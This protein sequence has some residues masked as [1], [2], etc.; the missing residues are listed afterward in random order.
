MRIME[1]A[2]LPNG[3]H[4]NQECHGVIPDGWAVIP[5]GMEL[6]HFPFGQAEAELTEGVL[7]LTAWTPGEMPGQEEEPVFLADR[8]AALEMAVQTGLTLY[9]EEA[10]NG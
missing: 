1:V 8:V 6:E 4:R 7:T 9:E 3:G 2:A 10:N 5:E